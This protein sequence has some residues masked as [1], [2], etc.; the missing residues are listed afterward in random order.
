MLPDYPR[1]IQ[2]DIGK[3]LPMSNAKQKRNPRVIQGNNVTS[4]PLCNTR[5]QALSGC[6]RV[7]QENSLTTNA[8]H[9]GRMSN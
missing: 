9:K 8:H 2:E 6:P 1:V 4:L 5:Q 3:N 7:R